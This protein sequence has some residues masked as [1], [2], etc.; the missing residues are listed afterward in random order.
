M[1]AMHRG[2][3]LIPPLGLPLKNGIFLGSGYIFLVMETNKLWL[4]FC[5]LI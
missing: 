1:N 4:F 2:K 5:E 3:T